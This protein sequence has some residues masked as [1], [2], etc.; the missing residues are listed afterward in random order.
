MN[1]NIGHNIKKYRIESKMTQGELAKQLSVTISSI[2]A[3]ENG[4]RAPSYDVII[5][6]ASLFRVSTD[7]LLGHSNSFSSDIGE[8]TAEQKLVVYEIIELYKLKN[9]QDLK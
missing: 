7:N 1:I 8:L 4:L 6:I 9:N 3:Y 2:S 5:K